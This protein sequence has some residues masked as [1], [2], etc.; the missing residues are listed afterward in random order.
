MKQ[1]DFPDLKSVTN[2]AQFGDYI[3][4]RLTEVPKNTKAVL[5]NLWGGRGCGKSAYLNWLLEQL[6]PSDLVLACNLWIWPE[7]SDPSQLSDDIRSWLLE[8]DHKGD[9]NKWTVILLDHIESIQQDGTDNPSFVDFEQDFMLEMVQKTGIIMIVT[10][11]HEIRQ[12][13]EPLIRRQQKSLLLASPEKDEFLKIASQRGLDAEQA[14]QLTKGNLKAL[15]W[16]QDKTTRRKLDIDVI[17]RDFFLDPLSPEMRNC[18]WAAS[19]LLRFDREALNLVLVG[20]GFSD[21]A[22]YADDM[23]RVRALAFA[24][25][26]AYDVSEGLYYFTDASTRRLLARS[27]QQSNPEIYSRILEKL[28][29]HYWEEAQLPYSLHKYF[30]E[31]IYYAALTDQQADLPTQ[32]K[33]EQILS[34]IESNQFNWA[35]MDV[36]KVI[37]AWENGHG[38]PEI[39]SELQDLLG[40]KIFNTI[41][42]ELRQ[43]ERMILA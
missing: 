34:Q 11:L 25:L 17:A 7:Y 14:Y 16:L 3:F 2:Q 8:R 23:A 31:T 30:V 4:Q 19:L 29:R 43:H 42:A 5:L 21:G 22:S 12:W 18:A 1:D 32:N 37:Y 36:S 33:V 26:L 15:E 38:D 27:Y 24:G 20:A 9:G 13:H 28:A 41:S 39:A 6:E 35:D 40:M 10:S